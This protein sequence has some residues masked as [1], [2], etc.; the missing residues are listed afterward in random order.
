[1]SGRV[2]EFLRS[3]GERFS[4]TF[5]VSKTATYVLGLC[6]ASYAINASV[7]FSDGLHTQRVQE[8]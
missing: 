3:D 1:M 5:R 6:G 2:K 7:F 4:V 8:L